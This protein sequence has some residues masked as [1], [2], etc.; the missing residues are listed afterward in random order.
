MPH[1]HPPAAY[2]ALAEARGFEWLGPEVPNAHTSTTWRCPHGHEWPAR[3]SNIQQGTG[4]PT[5][6]SHHQNRTPAD[7]ETLA[8]ERGFAWLGPEVPNA[9]TKTGWRCP[10]GHEWQARYANIQQ[11]SGCPRCAALGIDRKPRKGP[12]D[13]HALAAER[14]FEWLGPEVRTTKIKTTW[15]C[16][17]SAQGHEWQTGYANIKGGS[18]CPYCRW[19]GAGR[20]GRKLPADYET[21]AEAR[22]FEWLGPEVPNVST[23]TTWRCAQGHEW[24]ARYSNIQ[25]GSDCPTC[26][27]RQPRAPGQRRRGRSTP[28]DYETLAAER[29]FE[30]L[31]P[32]VPTT[33]TKTTW[34]C[35]QG[36]TWSARYSDLQRGTGCPTCC[37][38]QQRHSAADYHALAAERGYTWLGPAVPNVNTK[39]TWRCAQGH[40]W[41]APY[42]SIN[43]KRGCPHCSGKAPK[44]P[45]D[46]ETIAAGRGYEWLGPAVRNV[47]VKTGWRCDQGHEWQAR[48]A[49]L[50]QGYG[51]PYC[52]PPGRRRKD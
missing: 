42:S 19:P 32:E 28:A 4:C 31:G 50:Q 20:Q 22:G 47:M 35:G 36:H 10:Q 5:C 8:G 44:T 25:Q 37:N 15:R 46:Y 38:D 24:Q 43:T 16:T 40:E 26:A 33:G 2:E 21:L 3:Y 27:W 6:A 7:Y 39:T 14:G 23:K 48:Y 17:R 18:G 30:W 51:C 41:C 1:R 34:R 52:N 11:G 13:Y 29:G 49:N 9:Q 45:A 12:A